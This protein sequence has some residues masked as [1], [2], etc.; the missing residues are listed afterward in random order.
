MEKRVTN[1]FTMVVERRI[2]DY[3]V[4]VAP[5]WAGPGFFTT[6][7]IL[8]SLLIFISYYLTNLDS[9]FLLLVNLGIFLNWFGDSLDGSLARYRNIS[10]PQYG[11]FVDHA[12]DVVSIFLTGLG[13][14]LSPYL[15]L[16]VALLIVVGYLMM[17]LLVSLA[18]FAHGVFRLSFGRV[19]PTEMRIVLMTI[20]VALFA[21]Y[22]NSLPVLIVGMFSIIDLIA[23]AVGLIMVATFI[24]ATVS[25]LNELDRL[26][27][28]PTSG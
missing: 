18:T 4:R 22:N 26:D 9:K 10:R 6:I 2:L 13:L 23:L 21:L 24:L 14:G 11:Y 28:E 12:V 5:T 16:E 7:G 15:G 27:P 8:G 3:L 17:M 25:K 1:S 20:N 19:G